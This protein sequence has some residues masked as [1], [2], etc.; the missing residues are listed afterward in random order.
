MATRHIMV[1][2]DSEYL[3]TCAR[4]RNVT[5]STLL[6]RLV[7]AIDRDQLVLAVLDDEER[8]RRHERHQHCFRSNA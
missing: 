2:F 7:D 5:L 4:I 3:E 1:H 6:R 8:Y